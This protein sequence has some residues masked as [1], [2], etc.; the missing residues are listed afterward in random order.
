MHEMALCTEVV[1]TALSSAKE[2]DAVSVDAVSLVIG[3]TRDIVVDLFDG[4]FHFLARGT[5]AEGATVSY[6]RVP[7][8]A[9][10]HLCGQ[11]FPVDIHNRDLVVECSRCGQRDYEV[12]SGMEFYIESIDVTTSVEQERRNQVRAEEEEQE[13]Q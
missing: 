6:T 2:V 3:E 13:N 10:C 11:V 7:L 5:M 9:K 8:T 4:F 1:N 12:N